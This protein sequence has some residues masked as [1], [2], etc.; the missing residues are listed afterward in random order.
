M[1]D[2][3]DIVQEYHQQS[4][5]ITA[6]SFIFALGRMA[7]DMDDRLRHEPLDDEANQL[8]IEEY[9]KLLSFILDIFR[10]ASFIQDKV[11]TPVHWTMENTNT[12]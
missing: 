8:L 6:Q 1:R 7:Q 4:K 2:L 3:L 11:P 12:N 10:E 5:S 9:D